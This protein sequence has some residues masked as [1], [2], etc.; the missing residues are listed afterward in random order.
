MNEQLIELTEQ[1]LKYNQDF[2]T[3]YTE[4]RETNEQK[5]FF[6]Y[7]KPF[8]D[9]VAKVNKEWTTRLR[10]WLDENKQNHLYPHQVDSISEHIER[11][12]I[13]AFY[14]ETSKTRFLNA[15]RTVEYFL[16]ELGEELKNKKG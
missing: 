10:V 11:L 2:L 3:L 7:V 4:G 15:Q 13:Q 6:E 12:S 5:D 9:E 14:P 16:K 1:L 8:A